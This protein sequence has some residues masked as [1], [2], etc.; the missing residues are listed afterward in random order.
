MTKGRR[1]NHNFNEGN[2]RLYDVNGKATY[3]ET[4]DGWW[5]KCEYDANGKVIYRE[6]STGSWSKYEFDI[7]GNEIYY[8]NSIGLIRHSIW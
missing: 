3:Y 1:L 4:S 8:E 7:N 2:L 6:S 5:Y